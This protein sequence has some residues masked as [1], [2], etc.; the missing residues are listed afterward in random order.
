MTLRGVLKTER[1]WI[2]GASAVD[3]FGEVV[4]PWSDEA[5]A[6]DLV[7]ACIRAYG[8]E[9]YRKAVNLLERCIDGGQQIACRFNDHP[10][11]HFDSICDLITAAGLD[12]PIDLNQN[13]EPRKLI[14]AKAFAKNN[15]SF[16]IAPA[17]VHNGVCVNVIDL[18]THTS[19]LYGPKRSVRLGFEIDAQRNDGRNFI[20]YR[21]FGFT[22]SKKS[23]LRAILDSWRGKPFSEQEEKEGYDLAKLLG[24]PAAI[25]VMHKEDNGNTYAN[26]GTVTKLM[27]GMT[28]MEPT[29][30]L[31]SFFFDD[32]GKNLPAGMPDWI[33]SKIMKSAEWN[34]ADEPEAT[35]DSNEQ[36]DAGTVEAQAAATF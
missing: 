2:K 26:I 1:D 7:G 19:Q 28:A 9:H 22:V 5:A 36:S 35:P 17:D 13:Q 21:D 25:Q 15:E 6:F 4:N 27:K 32:H 20:V 33:K 14:M 34:A 29:Q 31:I 11:I 10:S 3:T 16:P 30:P 18:G 12:Q 24:Q 8:L 23:A